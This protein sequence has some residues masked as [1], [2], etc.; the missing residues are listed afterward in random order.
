MEFDWV[1]LQFGTGHFDMN[2]LKAVNKLI[3]NDY[4]E[5]TAKVMNFQ[6]DRALAYAQSA[7][8]T[9]KAYDM[10]NILRFS[11]MAELVALYIEETVGPEFTFEKFVR[12]IENK[13]PTIAH[14]WYVITHVI[15][16]FFIFHGGVRRNNAEYIV[17]GAKL[18]L[19]LFQ[20]VNSRN[21]VKIIQHY[22]SQ[23]A[24][25][26]KE[27]VASLDSR[28]SIVRKSSTVG[29]QGLDFILEEENKR[30]KK[31]LFP[32]ATEQEWLKSY[33]NMDTMAR[34]RKLAFEGLGVPDP[35]DTK[36]VKK[37]SFSA[38]VE[39][40][41]IFLRGSQ[42]FSK[43]HLI[44]LNFKLELLESDVRNELA[45]ANLKLWQQDPV[46]NAEAQSSS[47]EELNPMSDESSDSDSEY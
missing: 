40:T 24:H 33:R 42:F 20:S 2:Y 29:A 16:P 6:T 36:P 38:E 12:F 37:K 4:M 44:C 14:I 34:L 15:Q 11:V 18:A 45:T 17:A 28:V 43:D 35:N 21:Y 25:L 26:P 3:W 39:K 19:P 7:S 31:F 8:D 46:V 22:L 27:V 1:V 32:S 41:R 10:I 13:N 47:E 9:H 23:R 5:F 30:A